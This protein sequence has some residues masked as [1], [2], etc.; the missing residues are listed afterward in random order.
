MSNPVNLI[1]IYSWHYITRT[2]GEILETLHP[3]LFKQVCTQTE[4]VRAQGE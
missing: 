4:K 1:C 3:S 2:N